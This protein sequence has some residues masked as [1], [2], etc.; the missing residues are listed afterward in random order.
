MK[1]SVLFSCMVLSLAVQAVDYHVDA[2]CG[3]DANDGLSAATAW[4]TAERAAKQKLGPGDRLLLKAGCIWR[5]GAPFT[6]RARGTAASPV[7]RKRP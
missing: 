7:R 4:R 2:K 1:A 3:D 5:L 6:L